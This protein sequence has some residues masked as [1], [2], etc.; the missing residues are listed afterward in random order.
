[1]LAAP[2]VSRP[3]HEDFEDS[4]HEHGRGEPRHR[5]GFVP[6][7]RAQRI[8]A[9]ARIRVRRGARQPIG[10]A[11]FASDARVT[12]MPRRARAPMMLVL[13][14]LIRAATLP[15]A[16]SVVRREPPPTDATRTTLAR[17]APSSQRTRAS[18]TL[19]PGGGPGGSILASRP[20]SFLE[21][22]EG[23]GPRVR[24]NSSG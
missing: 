13:A 16:D 5:R 8:D 11:S 17:H 6:V 3:R 9:R 18:R 23:G 24:R 10:D 22:G 19:P 20:G 21:S 7:D 4:A 15:S 2:L 12:T 1:M 14:L